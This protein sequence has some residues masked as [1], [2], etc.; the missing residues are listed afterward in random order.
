MLKHS[1]KGG[2]TCNKDVQEIKS[3]A[4]RIFDRDPSGYREG[5]SFPSDSD[6]CISTLSSREETNHSGIVGLFK[7]LLDNSDSISTNVECTKE[8]LQ[9]N[10]QK[11][12][13]K[14]RV[15]YKSTKYKNNDGYKKICDPTLDCVVEG[16]EHLDIEKPKQV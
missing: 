7:S 6:S 8:C 12:K 13:Y 9:L 1:T 15:S 10:Q 11:L 14:N 3:N 16:V 2:Q 4:P 5:T